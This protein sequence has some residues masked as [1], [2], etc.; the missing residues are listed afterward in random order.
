MEKLISRSDS[1]TKYEQSKYDDQFDD[2]ID[3]MDYKE[4]L[5]ENAN[6]MGFLGWDMSHGK[7]AVMLNVLGE[8]LMNELMDDT[9]MM[10]EDKLREKLRGMQ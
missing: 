4:L 3:D 9:A 1:D 5:K 6:K 10:Y 8:E 2:S 7:F